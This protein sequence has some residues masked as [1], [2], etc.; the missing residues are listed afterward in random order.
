MAAE[1]P[2]SS[3]TQ[4]FG[5][6]D[7]AALPEPPRAPA[8]AAPASTTQELTVA[9]AD[10]APPPPERIGGYAVVGILGQGGMGT[11]YECHDPGLDRRVAVKV[12]KQEL[13]ADLEMK[14]RFLREARAMAKVSSPHVVAVYA[15]GE[16]GGA[17]FIVME[18]L[19]G[20]DLSERLRC[21]GPLPPDAVVA[22]LRDAV[23]GLSAAAKGGLV[24]RDV[25]PA[26][27]FLVDGRTKVT[28]FGLARPMD[29]SA[30]VTQ[31]GLIVGT[32]HY[33]APE[34]GRGAAASVASD[35]YALGATAFELLAG[36]PP[37]T[38]DTPVQALA[39][40][41]IEPT[42]RV[43]DACPA[44]GADLAHIIE[45]A[46]AKAPAAR[47]GAYEE[48]EAALR[49][50]GS[51]SGPVKVAK[52]ALTTKAVAA[53]TQAPPDTVAPPTPQ[54][55]NPALRVSGSAHVAVKTRSLTVMFT[56]I[57]GYT[58]RTSQQ[59]REQAARWLALHDELLLPVLRA[60]GGTLIKNIGDALLVTF[61]SP[62]D[63]V[64]CG[65]AIQ[66]RLFLHNK[67]APAQDRIEVRVAISAGEVRLQR[68]DIFGEPVNLAARLESIG[69]RGE[70]LITDAV[71]STMNTAEVQLESRG[72]STF[73][74]IQRAVHVYAAVPNRTPGALPFGG[75]ALSRVDQAGLLE[76]AR[77]RIT[78]GAVEIVRR[79][80]DALPRVLALLV[81]VPRKARLGAG[82]AL[83][84][85]AAV[86]LLVKLI[87]GVT[88]AGAPDRGRNDDDET[89]ALLAALDAQDADSA[90]RKLQMLTD[91]D[92][93]D[94]L[95]SL[96]KTGSWWQRHHALAILED[97]GASVD[98]EAFGIQDLEE[99]TSCARRRMGLMLLKRVAASGDALDAVRSAGKRQPDNVCMLFDFAAAESAI[100]SRAR[101]KPD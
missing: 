62:T 54:P 82:G 18:K 40:H 34:L 15:V 78:T 53:P 94:E 97:R 74:G 55:S 12:L 66:D 60:F 76:G 88:G 33:M 87:G 19:D 91:G 38:G 43:L 68:G 21:R 75:H 80:N 6:G 47:F 44:A 45:R 48:L 11:V 41:I 10:G 46:L 42:P 27:L 73:R 100:R 29:G 16:D 5:S 25:K 3:A 39:A 1:T 79:T 96:T 31:A 98:R 36:R 7:G 50:L 23:A 13:A 101:A 26:N 72:A 8:A 14:T 90:K 52:I 92:V 57:A 85:V 22:I 17:P 28:D 71:Y 89:E 30:G 99:G 4:I 51:T 70:V 20:E 59:S 35:I 69:E 67:D 83:V 61:S 37:F 2:R 9:R 49:A 81:R 95:R 64:H 32:P 93:D 63:A 24:H 84:V 56:D 77:R 58:E 86:A 65:T